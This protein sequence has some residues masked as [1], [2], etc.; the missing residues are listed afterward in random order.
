MVEGVLSDTVGMTFSTLNILLKTNILIMFWGSCIFGCTQNEASQKKSKDANG[1]A[2][3]DADKIEDS[4]TEDTA[5]TGNTIIDPDKIFL[6]T[7][8]SETKKA[9]K[10]CSSQLGF[11][12]SKPVAWPGKLKK[13]LGK[14]LQKLSVAGKILKHVTGIYLVDTTGS[15]GLPIVGGVVCG[16]DASVDKV[17]VIMDLAMMTK[18]REK[19]GSIDKPVKY[20]TYTKGEEENS[21]IVGHDG[22]YGVQ[23]LIHELMHVYDIVYVPNSGDEKLISAHKSGNA[24]AWKSLSEDKFG[25]VDKF[26]LTSFGLSDSEPT[27][28]QLLYECSKKRKNRSSTHMDGDGGLTLADSDPFKRDG[29]DGELHEFLIKNTSFINQYSSTNRIEDFAESFTVYFTGTRNQDWP[30]RTYY[31]FDDANNGARSLVFKFDAKESAST[32]KL[33]RKKMCDFAKYVLGENCAKFLD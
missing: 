12:S 26:G 1:V 29:S 18:D 24:V 23:T 33:H 19:L 32:S 28:M 17:P 21:Y 30:E 3:T 10:E 6:D 16:A 2:E 4:S 5:A 20:L 11:P 27:A 15:E 31:K 25:V 13:F 9:L 8:D 7:A 22:D 14:E